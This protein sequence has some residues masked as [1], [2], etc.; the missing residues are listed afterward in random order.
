M[1][2]RFLIFLI[3][4]LIIL[5]QHSFAKTNSVLYKSDELELTQKQIPLKEKPFNKYFA[6]YQINLVNKTDSEIAVKG[7]VLNQASNEQTETRLMQFANER[8]KLKKKLALMGLGWL[9]VS[10]SV[11]AV[12]APPLIAVG[13]L[14]KLVG[15]TI[16][17]K[18]DKKHTNKNNTAIQT[19]LNKFVNE[20]N[21]YEFK[22]NPHEEQ[23]FYYL[24]SLLPEAEVKLAFQVVYNTNEKNPIIIAQGIKED[25]AKQLLK[26]NSAEEVTK[27]AFVAG[28]ISQDTK[29]GLY[30]A[31][32]NE[33]KKPIQAV[34]K[35]QIT[36]LQKNQKII[37]IDYDQPKNII[38]LNK[39]GIF[40]YQNIFGL[41]QRHQLNLYELNYSSTHKQVSGKLISFALKEIQPGVFEV[42][43]PKKDKLELS[44][45]NYA[46]LQED[47]N[48]LRK[49]YSFYV[50][51]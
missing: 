6:L 51:N 25:I 39:E 29:A 13:V 26:D 28:E 40:I 15:A 44:S 16:L 41:P 43:T 4:L 33:Y 42:R 3:C 5:P 19:T 1:T 14:Q 9:A 27:Y 48:G 22:V 24:I 2:S 45:G 37:Q 12:I 32:S 8:A 30:A 17:N 50:T 38:N 49:V 20:S 18:I 35:A 10:A 46:I 47:S 23:S 31:Y 34:C 7:L 11:G 21:T 36:Q